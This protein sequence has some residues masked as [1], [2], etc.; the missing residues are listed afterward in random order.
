MSSGFLMLKR[1][2]ETLELLKDGDAFLLLT[3]I[4]YRARRSA[5]GVNPY[6]LAAGEAMLGDYHNC[7]LSERRARTA[8]AK[9]AKWGLAT[10]RATNRGTIAKLCNSAVFDAN[11]EP[12]D[13][14]N[15]RPATSQR[16]AKDERRDEPETSGATSQRRLTIR[17]KNL[18]RRK[19]REP[20]RGPPA[21]SFRRWKRWRPTAERTAA[22]S[23]PRRS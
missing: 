16:Q 17:K 22:R 11:I 20:L 12:R 8:K 21:S 7:G 10:F 1:G 4:A 5:D 13:E 2:P 3:Q 14:Q 9:L 15:D 19:K 18:R 23:T 6:N